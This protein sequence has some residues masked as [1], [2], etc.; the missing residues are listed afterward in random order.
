[1]RSFSA[2]AITLGLLGCDRG[3]APPTTRQLVAGVRS[4]CLLDHGSVTCWGELEDKNHHAPTRIEG[5]SDA[6]SICTGLTNSCVRDTGGHVRCWGIDWTN[7]HPTG[8]RPFAIDGLS[9]VTQLACGRSHV[10]ALTKDGD[11]SCW[12]SN[13]EGATGQPKSA[14][15]VKVAK[16]MGVTD[17]VDLSA[18]ADH[19]CILHR[20]GGVSC[21]GAWAALS[22]SEPLHR[23]PG[24]T[25]ITALASGQDFVCGLTASKDVFCYGSNKLG[26]LGPG[27][28]LPHDE[29]VRVRGL[30][31]IRAISAR[32]IHACAL[33]ADGGVSCW[34]SEFGHGIM[35]SRYDNEDHGP[36]RI[37]GIANAVALGV[38]DAHACVDQADGTVTCWGNNRDGQ[39]G[40]P[41]S[42]APHEP[43]PVAL[44]K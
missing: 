37:T 2:V 17:A 39:T 25:N 42:N 9:G 10:C 44:R 11:V 30:A 29:A 33:E 14:A 32:S 28:S 22:P 23:V 40:Q 1:M 18:G 15:S 16:R 5:I 21:V 20:D 36:V 31:G 34:G 38:G 6:V 8:A 26:Q 4:S 41:V 3:V 12:G 27:D 19:T 43:M 13:F 7:K 35:P 24:L